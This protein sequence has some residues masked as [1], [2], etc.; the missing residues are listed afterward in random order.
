M[1]KKTL[2]L[3]LVGVLAS[4]FLFSSCIGSFGLFNKL[5]DWNKNID[6]KFVNELVFVAFCIVPVYPIAYLADV[7]VINSIEFWSGTNPVADAGIVKK[8][9][10][11]EGL[12]AIETTANGYHIQKEGD[13]EGLD[14]IFDETEQTWSYDYEGETNKLFKFTSE[15]DVVMFLPD[16]KEVNVELSQAGVYAF[17]Q[18]AAETTY[19]AAR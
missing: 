1:K 2:K 8:V 18:I 10:T 4:S 9:E 16:G 15:D 7:L 17:K 13:A 11:P 5:L 19:F 3:M 14:L 12:Y 6:S